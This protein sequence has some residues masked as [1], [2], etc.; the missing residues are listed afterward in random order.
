MS[1]INLDL[2]IPT[3]ADAAATAADFWTTAARS[4]RV[5]VCHSVGRA[6]FLCHDALEILLSQLLLA[7][8]VTLRVLLLWALGRPSSVRCVACVEKR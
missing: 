8:H 2:H 4:Y 1:P 6:P 5:V 3:D 7:E